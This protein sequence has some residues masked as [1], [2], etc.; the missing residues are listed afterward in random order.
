[1]ELRCPEEHA[2]SFVRE[3]YTRV[4]TGE[5][6]TRGHDLFEHGLY[7]VDCKRGY[8]IDVLVQKHDSNQHEKNN[9]FSS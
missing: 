5:R 2:V 9:F 7:C 8:A 6:D 4:Y 3:A 1:M